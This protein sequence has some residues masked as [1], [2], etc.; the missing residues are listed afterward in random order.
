MGLFSSK[1]KPSNKILVVDDSRLIQQTQGFEVRQ[2]GYE[3]V[4]ANSGA[5]ALAIAEKEPPLLI[6]LD[7]M[8]P[9]MDGWETCLRLKQNPVTKDIP[10]IMATG[11][12]SGAGLEKG[13][14][15]GVNAYVIKPVTKE[16]LK[17]KFEQLLPKPAA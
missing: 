8:M 1:P 16:K 15:V 14:Q 6:L 17:P 9:E 5:D 10:V 4:F 2:L 7:C 3:V 11:D 12:S 13:F